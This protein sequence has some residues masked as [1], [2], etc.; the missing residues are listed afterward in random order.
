MQ[1]TFKFSQDKTLYLLLKKCFNPIT[2][3]PPFHISTFFPSSLHHYL[4]P[5]IP[6]PPLYPSLFPPSLFHFLYSHFL[7]PLSISPYRPS[8]INYFSTSSLPPSLTHSLHSFIVSSL[9]L[10]LPIYLHD[11]FPKSLLISFSK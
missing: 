11:S 6:Y 2:T 9:P 7:S 3:S 5:F 1:K 4:H 8:L 10:F